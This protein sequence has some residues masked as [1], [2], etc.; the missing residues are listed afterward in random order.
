MCHKILIDNVKSSLELANEKWAVSVL[1][2]EQ[3]KINFID[4]KM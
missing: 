2:K 1:L 3:L 4:P